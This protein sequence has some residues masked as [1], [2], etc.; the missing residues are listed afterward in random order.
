MDLPYDDRGT[1]VDPLNLERDGERYRIYPTRTHW[2]LIKE[3]MAAE[4]L[5]K[6]CRK[7]EGLAKAWDMSHAYIKENE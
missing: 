5:C 4:V 1:G 3:S 6:L 2:V 7:S